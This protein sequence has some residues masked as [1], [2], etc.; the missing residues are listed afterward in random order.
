M[1]PGVSSINPVV[2]AV[3]MQVFFDSIVDLVDPCTGDVVR[4]SGICS[5]LLWGHKAVWARLGCWHAVKSVL[6]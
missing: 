5:V 1:F 6:E 3:F 2:T 4:A